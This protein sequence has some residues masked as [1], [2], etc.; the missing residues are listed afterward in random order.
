MVLDNHIAIGEGARAILQE[1][2]DCQVEVF[3]DPCIAL[4]YLTE[5]VY[6]IYLIEFNLSGMDG[7]QFIDLLLKIHPGAITIIYTGYNIEKYVPDLL[8]R[9]IS[10][11]ISKAES[12]K[13][14]V[15]TIQ[16]ARQGKIIISL[17]LLN[18]LK[19]HNLC[20]QKPVSL[21]D[22]ERKIL[23][24]VRNGLTNKAI[25]LELYLSQRTIEKELTTIF[26]KL[27]VESRAEAAIKWS[28]LAVQ[29]RSY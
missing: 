11:F 12:R 28:E 13:Q 23:D 14:L 1:E 18:R 25:A 2:I 22:R 7:I 16:Y 29:K 19:I 21:T 5:V 24:L 27:D 17:S 4:Q 8:D 26:S 15:D 10:G 6:D 20:C 9:G 3:T